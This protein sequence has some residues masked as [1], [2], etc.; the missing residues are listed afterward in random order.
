MT[1]RDIVLK[2]KKLFHDN[3]AQFLSLFDVPLKSYWDDVTGLDIVKLDI[4]VVNSGD[5][6]MQE[7]VQSK[8]GAEAVNLIHRLL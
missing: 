8:F 6:C 7:A 3:Q 2:N 5:L 1:L 4:E